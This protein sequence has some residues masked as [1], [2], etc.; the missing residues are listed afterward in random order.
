[1]I[2]IAMHKDTKSLIICNG[3]KDDEFIRLALQGLRLGKEIYV[4]EQI[5]ELPRI[6]HMSKSSVLIHVS[7]FA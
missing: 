2:A 6:I 3:Y 1:M 5:S 7:D 4:V